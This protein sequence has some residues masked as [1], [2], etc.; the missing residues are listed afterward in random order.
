MAVAADSGDYYRVPSDKRD[1]NYA[2]YF[3]EGSEKVGAVEDYNSHNT[4]RLD[5]DGLIELLKKLE[6]VK[7]AVAGEKIEV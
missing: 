5:V 1:L 2:S 4:R 3:S 7:R 6:I